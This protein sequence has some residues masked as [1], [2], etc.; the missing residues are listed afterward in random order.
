MVIIMCRHFKKKVC[1]C[2]KTNTFLDKP[3]KKYCKDCGRYI[4]EHVTKP[5]SLINQGL[6]KIKKSV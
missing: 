3:Y 5:I 4:H 6:N 2:C 1:I